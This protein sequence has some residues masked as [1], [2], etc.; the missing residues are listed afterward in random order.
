LGVSGQEV[1]GQDGEAKVPTLKEAITTADPEIVECVAV[2]RSHLL[3][4]ILAAH[5]PVVCDDGLVAEIDFYEYGARCG[6]TADVLTSLLIN[7]LYSAS[8]LKLV[9]FVEVTDASYSSQGLTF[10]PDP[11]ELVHRS[12]RRTSSWLRGPTAWVS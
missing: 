8:G 3:L 12:T 9:P 10:R 7:L 6:Q 5:L 11:S 1:G 2:A 4:S